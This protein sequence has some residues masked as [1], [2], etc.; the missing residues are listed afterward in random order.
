MNDYWI[1][2]LGMGAREQ[3][4][5]DRWD[6]IGNGLFRHELTSGVRPG[7]RT[8]EGIVYYA[9]GTGLIFAVGEI[10]SFPFR[11]DDPDQP[12]W[13][14]RVKV[15]LTHWRD[16]IPD[17]VPLEA[18]NVEERDLRQTIKRRSHIRLSAA[19][20]DEAVR[21]LAIPAGV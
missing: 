2:A 16:F 11:S 13:P 8:G 15:K 4:L 5:P 20:Y 12:H 10:T 9:S 7:M 1:K 17:G 19:E 14:W 3:Q 6:E 18:L 21:L